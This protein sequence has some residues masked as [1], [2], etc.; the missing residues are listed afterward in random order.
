[1]SLRAAIYLPAAVEVARWLP[2]CLVHCERNAYTVASIIWPSLS[3]WDAVIE[4]LAARDVDVVVVA[5]YEHLPSDRTPRIEEATDFGP[6][7]PSQRR[8]RRHHPDQ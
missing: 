7:P 5:S 3:G 1:M 2:I 8:P 4:L 6:G